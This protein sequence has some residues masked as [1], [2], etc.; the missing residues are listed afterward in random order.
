M[1]FKT[2][3]FSVCFLFA[4][5]ALSQSLQLSGI[6]NISESPD[7][8]M[9][10]YL[11]IENTTNTDLDIMVSKSELTI[12]NNSA[13]YFCFGAVCYTDAVYTSVYP[14]NILAN[15]TSDSL[16]TSYYDAYGNS[17][18]TKIKYCFYPENSIS[19]STCIVVTFNSVV[20][21]VKNESSLFSIFP[22]PATNRIQIQLKNSVT[23][24]FSITDMS[25]IIMFKGNLH[26]IKSSIDISKL[27]NGIYFVTAGNTTTK[28]IKN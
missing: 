5:I 4:H 9:K 17:G 3:L 27:S 21:S 1:N 28:F 10:T 15:T 20:T 25:G 19:D 24:G 2:I 7:V 18:T 22:N 13:N 12:V 8:Q 16:F 14:E 23:Q 6:T 11:H 26:E